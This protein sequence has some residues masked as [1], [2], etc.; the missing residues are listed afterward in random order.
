MP[1]PTEDR[2]RGFLIFL[3]V[4]AVVAGG[5]IMVIEVM[6]SR[7]IGPFFGVSL[8]VWTSLI[9]VTLIALAAG[10]ALGGIAADRWS[11]PDPMYG[12]I[13]LAG[14]LVLLIPHW[15][16]WVIERSA[17]LGLR[18]GSFV[19]SL[20]LFGPPL[21]LLGCVS[22]FLVKMATRE[23]DRLGRTVG[24]F[25]ALSTLG[26]VVG[27]V[28][29]GFVLIAYLGVGRIFGLVGSMLILLGMA[30]FVVFRRRWAALLPGL[31]IPLLLTNPYE[32]GTSVL[33]ENGTRATSV[34]AVE[35]FYG[36]LKVVDYSYQNVR[37][38]ELSIDGLVQGGIDLQNGM[39]IYGYSYLLEVLPVS[40]YPE[41][42]SCLVIGLGA[43]LVPR[44]F[45]RRGV[46]TDVVDID[47]K[48]VEVADRYF[49]FKTSGQVFIGD[50]RYHLSSTDRRYDYLIVDVFSGDV[51]PGYLVSREAVEILRRR[52]SP[53]G[54]VALNLIGSLE[55]RTLMTASMVETLK[56]AF[57]TVDIYPT[58]EPSQEEPVGNLVIVAY[59]GPRRTPVLD[60]Q[61]I[62]QI[63]PWVRS[64]VV[65]VLDNRFEFSANT[66]SIILSD[67]FNPIDV[68]D[69]WLRETVRRN[70]LS[71][72]PGEI[73]L[74]SG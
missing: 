62:N 74:E 41:G 26:S 29:T 9:A 35:S 50:A 5:V 14:V 39:S 10:Y 30:Y 8:F 31:L 70:I 63:H 68:Q 33:L 54:V 28:L 55:Y 60:V 1:G 66:P 64:K 58:F 43:G 27:T 71:G 22:P 3:M 18:V 17:P 47:P 52:L 15:S 21:F 67:D 6:G 69:A 34:A 25:Y 46:A 36:S 51:T 37:T 38:R 24:G 49:G 61:E 13:V 16:S 7:V 11:R 32:A 73:L 20:A 65:E 56:T 40:L 59:D 57:D 12:I 53:D 2:G 23:V 4:T 19:S 72:T 42:R 45:E 48:V 44:G